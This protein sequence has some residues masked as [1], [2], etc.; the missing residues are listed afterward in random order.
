MTHE[1]AHAVAD[2]AGWRGT[3]IFNEGSGPWRRSTRP[4]GETRRRDTTAVDLAMAKWWLNL[5]GLD[6][7]S[8]RGRE[9]ELARLARHVLPKLGCRCRSTLVGA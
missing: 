8:E 3:S 6:K 1:L 2:R 9:A 5:V 7:P 4:G